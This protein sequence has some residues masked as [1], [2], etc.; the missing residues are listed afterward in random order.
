MC[1]EYISSSDDDTEKIKEHITTVHC[2]ECNVKKLVEMCRE[3]EER[4]EIEGWSLDD[5]IEKE[6]ER[7]EAMEK[8]RLESRAEQLIKMFRCNSDPV[9][10]ESDCFLCNEKFYLNSNVYCKHLEK[11]HMTLFGLKEIRECGGEE[12]TWL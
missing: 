1:L 12:E 5:I 3:A 2:A 9:N 4:E 6:R 11:K 8:R 7:R 10:V